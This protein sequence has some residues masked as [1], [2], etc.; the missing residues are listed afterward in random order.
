MLNQFED[1]LRTQSEHT[2]TYSQLKKALAEK[3][4]SSMVDYTE[5]RSNLVNGT[6]E[7]AKK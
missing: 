7:L 3:Y 5:G 4:R 6:I 1:F 2:Q